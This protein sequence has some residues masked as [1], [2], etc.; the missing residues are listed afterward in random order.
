MRFVAK[1]LSRRAINTHKKRLPES[2]EARKMLFGSIAGFPQCRMLACLFCKQAPNTAR[3]VKLVDA[4]DSKSPA[5]R[6]AG[7]SP[8]PGTT[9]RSAKVHHL[10]DLF[11]FPSASPYFASAEVRM[12][13]RKANVFCEYKCGYSPSS[14]GHMA[15]VA[16][17]STRSAALAL[18]PVG[19]A[20]RI[21]QA[22]L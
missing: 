10:P 9:S 13:S 17:I 15:K 12:C 11:L 8:A 20:Q 5:A 7:S 22:N 19:S 6:R 3:V 1:S 18:T 21:A 2:Q 16:A 14:C 4:G